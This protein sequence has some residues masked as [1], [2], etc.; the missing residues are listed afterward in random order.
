VP[1][2]TPGK[3]A[4]IKTPEGSLM[5]INYA[6]NDFIMEE[7]TGAAVPLFSNTEGVGRISPFL[8]QPDIF[9][10]IRGYLNL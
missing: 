5:A 8:Q 6:T 4:R 3:I 7:H 2:F 9:R 1:V 10:I